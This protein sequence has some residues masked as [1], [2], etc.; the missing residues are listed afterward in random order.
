MSRRSRILVIEIAEE[1]LPVPFTKSAT[2]NPLYHS[3]ESCGRG[4]LTAND[5]YCLECSSSPHIALEI[6]ENQLEQGLIN[7]GHY[8][9]ECNKLK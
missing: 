3:C 4:R 1:V 7:E 9:R 6:L 8:L 5:K 2:Q